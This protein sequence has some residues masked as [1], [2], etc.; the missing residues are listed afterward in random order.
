VIFKGPDSCLSEWAKSKLQAGQGENFLAILFH[1]P[2]CQVYCVRACIIV[3]KS[4]LSFHWV[5]VAIYTSQF[6]K[7]LNI[8]DYIDSFHFG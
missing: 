8:A 7:H 2:Q 4:D 6:V 1:F 5:V 3:L